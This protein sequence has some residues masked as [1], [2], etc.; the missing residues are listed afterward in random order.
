MQRPLNVMY[1]ASEIDTNAQLTIYNTNVLY[2][3]WKLQEIING[4]NI[5]TYIAIL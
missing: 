1:K 5:N 4:P 2:W 3:Y